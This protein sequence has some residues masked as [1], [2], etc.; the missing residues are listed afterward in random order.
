MIFS[1]QCPECGKR[2]ADCS[3]RKRH[4]L[5]HH[6]SNIPNSTKNVALDRPKK[7]RRI[8][9]CKSTEIIG[10]SKENKPLTTLRTFLED[11]E[12]L[13]GNL[14]EK[15]DDSTSQIEEL[16]KN[17]VEPDVFNEFNENAHNSEIQTCENNTLTLTVLED[18]DNRSLEFLSSHTLLQYD[19][20]LPRIEEENF[21]QIKNKLISNG[22]E[23]S[24][25]YTINNKLDEFNHIF[26]Q[27]DVEKIRLNNSVQCH[28]LSSTDVLNLELAL[29]TLG[30]EQVDIQQ[31]WAADILN[32]IAPCETQSILKML[33]NQGT[34]LLTF[35]E[36]EDFST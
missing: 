30:G 35:P 6:S 8:Q 17:N 16:A 1:V 27:T 12:L 7:K 14:N 4:A 10:R 34:I 18:D 21:L 36:N 33:N 24:E 5:Q 11:P 29:G 28:N 3:N 2:F 32:N 22:M 23:Q 15:R 25:N 19:N 9:Q 26:N 31:R 20:I 13:L